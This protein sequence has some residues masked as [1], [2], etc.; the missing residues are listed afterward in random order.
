MRR[1]FTFLKS[2]FIVVFIA[3]FMSGCMSDKEPKVFEVKDNFNIYDFTGTWYEMGSTKNDSNLSNI[4]INFAVDNNKIKVVKAGIKPNGSSKK[5]QYVGRFGLSDKNVSML[6]I[7]K[8]GLLYEPL[9]I[10]RNDRYQYAM[11]YIGDKD[12]SIISRTKT[13]PEVMKVIY[14]DKAK[15]D[16]FVLSRIKWIKQK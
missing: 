14:K 1:Y 7:S 16:G 11:M 4:S 9:Y 2:S 12:L 10:V 15:A 13:I 8:F 6:E 3:F 5:E